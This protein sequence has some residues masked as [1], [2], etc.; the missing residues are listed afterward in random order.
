MNS[1]RNRIVLAVVLAVVSGTLVVP[2]CTADPTKRVLVDDCALLPTCDV[3]GGAYN[4]R[5]SDRDAT[6]DVY[7]DQPVNLK[8]VTFDLQATN[9]M[10]GETYKIFFDWTGYTPGDPSTI[11][12]CELVGTVVAD[13]T[14]SI[15]W[16]YTPDLATRYYTVCVIVNW[17]GR[18]PIRGCKVNRSM[19]ISDANL[20]FTINNSQ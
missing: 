19:L 4:D 16:L 11:G 18:D 15:S 6:G 14:G 17:V 8:T 12:G 3:L 2:I 5:Y 10:P 13:S 7:V 9:L 20:N 1:R